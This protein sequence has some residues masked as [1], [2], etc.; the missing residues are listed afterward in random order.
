MTNLDR[1]TTILLHIQKYCTEIEGNFKFFG[2]H[3]EVFKQN[4]IFRDSISMKIFQIPFQQKRAK[5]WERVNIVAI[6]DIPS[7]QLD[8]VGDIAVFLTANHISAAGTG[9]C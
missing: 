2:K 3:L 8:S 7:G 6:S 5:I 4:N 1:K 9:N